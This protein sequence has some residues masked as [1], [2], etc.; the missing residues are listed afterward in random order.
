MFARSYPG[1]QMA[2]AVPS[3]RLG[4]VKE[5]RSEYVGFLCAAAPMLPPGHRVFVLHD[6]DGF[7][8]VVSR[9]REEAIA[10][11]GRSQRHVCLHSEADIRRTRQHVG[12][13][14]IGDSCTAA[15]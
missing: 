13:V 3:K 11:I 6:E 10:D 14:P 9:T 15:K 12:F 2:A 4:Y 1:K 7:P 8:L 5:I